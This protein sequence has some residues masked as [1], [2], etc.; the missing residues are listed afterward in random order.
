MLSWLA[1]L[2][3]VWGPFRLFEYGSVRCLGALVTAFVLML[4]VM[5]GFIRWL[6]AKKYGET[7]AKNDGAAVVDA[8]REA[9]KGTPTM[10]GLALVGCAAAT[11]LLWCDPALPLTWVLVLGLV[12]FAGVGYLDDRTKI[13]QGAQGTPERVKFILLI[14]VS[15]AGGAALWWI[16]A[17]SGPAPEGVVRAADQLVL[18][19]VPL[20]H[21]LSLGLWSIAWSAFVA[22]ACANAVNFTDGMD[23]LASG[24]MIIAGLAFCVVAYLVARTDVAAYL[25]VPWVPDGTEVAVFCAALVGACLGFLWFNAAPALVFMGDTGSQ[26]LGGALGLAA[27]AVKQEFMLLLVGAVFVAEAASVLV[28]RYVFKATK[29]RPAGGFR[30]FRCAPLHHHYQMGGMPETRIVIRFWI[31][32]ALGALLAIATLKVR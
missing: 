18:P 4:V 32:A 16:G 3:H 29:H 26:A 31:I 9:K 21:S 10:G 27:L 25:G 7:G 30:V 15:A 28:Q 11:A 1:D 5:P 8:A 6:R 17:Q 12:A 24:A 2:Q 14:L 20:S 13:F 19:F 22:T 23:G